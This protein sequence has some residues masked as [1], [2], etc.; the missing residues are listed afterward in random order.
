MPLIEIHMLKGRTPEQK[1]TLSTA[2]VR[3]LKSLLPS[4]EIIS[5]NVSDV[6][7]VSYRNTTMVDPADASG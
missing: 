1:A 5:M 4:V 7:R 2:V 3:A 6:E